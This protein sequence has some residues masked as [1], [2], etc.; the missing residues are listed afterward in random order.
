MFKDAL[1][2]RDFSEDAL[3]LAKA[4]MIILND[5]FRHECFKFNGNFPSKCQENSIPSSLLSL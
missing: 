1:K 2:Q 4:A 5:A 3:I